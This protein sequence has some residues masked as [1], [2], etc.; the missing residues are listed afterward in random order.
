MTLKDM[1]NKILGKDE[2]EEPNITGAMDSELDK[3]RIEDIKLNEKEEKKILK[4]K[5]RLRKKKLLREETFGVK[6]NIEEN[7]DILRPK[8]NVMQNQLKNT[9]NTILSQNNLFKHKSILTQKSVLRNQ[10][11]RFK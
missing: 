10:K 7:I 8:V 2:K 3:L 4:E 9:D 5:I 1:V 11:N 6:G